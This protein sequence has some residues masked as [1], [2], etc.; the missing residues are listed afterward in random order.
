MLET[1]KMNIFLA[2]VEE[3]S[4]SAAAKKL[5]LSQP[6][7]SLQIQSLEQQLGVELFRRTGRRVE[8]T[9]AGQ[10]LIPMARQMIGLS[11]RIEETMCALRGKIVGRLVIGCGATPAQY[12]LPRLI[13]LF[14]QRHPEVHI[15]LQMM[16]AEEVLE[17]VLS[18]EIHL[19]VLSHRPRHRSIRVRDFMEDETVLLVPVN[20]PWANRTKVSIHNLLREDV[21]LLKEHD[22]HSSESL[23]AAMADVAD[24][25]EFLQAVIELGSPE[26]AISAVEAGM[27]MA[28]LS[29]TAA[30]KAV[31]AGHGAMLHFKEGPYTQTLYFCSNKEH[32]E[33]CARVGFCD[34]VHTDEARELIEEWMS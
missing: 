29:K 1:H 28:I 3:R 8:V 12:I 19:G 24:P 11:N 23:W 2:A 13:L 34:F 5:G 10:T 30:R 26:A 9:E 33:I 16:Q 14:R 27:G 15:Q 18:Q 7:V 22:Q 6:A 17:K 21:T 31:A 25:Y 32:P 4:F 20:H